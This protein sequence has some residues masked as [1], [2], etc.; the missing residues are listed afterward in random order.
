MKT[1][2]INET[3]GLA[4]N[5]KAATSSLTKAIADELYPELTNVRIAYPAD[6]LKAFRTGWQS[7]IPKLDDP[8]VTLLLV[9]D[10][11]DRF[12]SGMAQLGRMDVDK[13]LDEIE[14]GRASPHIDLQAKQLGK[15]KT[16]LY[17]FPNHLQELATEIGVSF[18]LPVIN[19]RNEGKPELTQAQTDRATILYT[20]DV[21]LFASIN[22]AGQVYAGQRP[23]EPE[24]PLYVPPHVTPRQF[25]LAL[26]SID[27][28]PEQVTALLS[29]EPDEMKKAQSLTEWEYASQIDRNHP[30][31]AT[32]GAALGKDSDGVDQLFIL[33][34]TL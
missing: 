18:P 22:T 25:R 4:F 30:M 29:Q 32:L 31:V 13:A 21:T 24:A 10:P 9:R 2:K 15:A 34:Q 5:R 11:L 12:R 33:A 16:K 26:I 6:G 28:M 7:I 8:A 1:F 17:K 20:E 27:I 14:S 3:T 19:E 23:K